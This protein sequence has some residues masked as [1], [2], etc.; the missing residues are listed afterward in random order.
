MSDLP[1]PRP[2]LEMTPQ[3]QTEAILVVPIA[4]AR[5]DRGFCS[6]IEDEYVRAYCLDDEHKPRM[7]WRFRRRIERFDRPFAHGDC[8]ECGAWQRKRAWPEDRVLIDGD[9]PT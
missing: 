7:V 3:F 4:P 6:H 8:P 5:L 1:P 9:R 2:F